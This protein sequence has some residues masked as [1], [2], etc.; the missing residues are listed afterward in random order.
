MD[1]AK[2]EIITANALLCLM[3]I[4]IHVSSI[5]ITTLPK[6]GLSYLIIFIPWRLSAFVVQGFIFLSGLKMF[7]KDN[8]N[9]SYK[10]YYISR[11]KKIV[12]PY[13]IWVVVYYLYFCFIAQYYPFD[14]KHLLTHMFRG[15]L[16][17]PFYFII[18]II[19]FY[20]LAP[21]WQKLYRNIRPSITFILSL[22]VT[23][24]LGMYLPAII[25]YITNGYIFNYNDRVFT[26]YLVYWSMG[27]IA[28]LNYDRFIEM[29]KNK[30]VI[31]SVL[32]ISLSAADLYF[33]YKSFA[34]SYSVAFLEN[35]HVF[36][37]ISAILF[38][39]LL[40]TKIRP[41]KAIS[42]VSS[43]SYSIF[44]SHCLV[45]YIINRCF[46]IYGTHGILIDFIIRFIFTYAITLSFCLLYKHII[47]YLKRIHN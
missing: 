42:S 12:V 26:K 31:I 43:V 41:N 38:I 21:L 25:E 6:D 18:V 11:F 2:K 7:L 13:I 5:P 8:K 22:A 28:G 29:I 10:K 37:C 34:L 19:Q 3:V 30:A 36:Y 1:T 9:I 40:S 39:M 44:L 45:I 15:T 47:Y 17:S 24:I 16:V 46:E 33:S 20:A 14:V 27:A 23:I 4:F 32:F 35:M